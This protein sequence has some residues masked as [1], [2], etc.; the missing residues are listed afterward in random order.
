VTEQKRYKLI[1]KPQFGLAHAFYVFMGGFAFYGPYHDNKPPVEGG[2][3][4]FEISTNPC[5]TVE[6]PNSDAVIYIM[7]YFPHILTDI[8]EDYIHSQA[9]SSSLGKA[10]LTV[11]VAWFC[12]NCASRLFQ[13]LPLTLLEI[14]TAAHALCTLLTYIVWWS[15]P[16]NVPA[17]TI[18]RE[19][20]AQEVYALLNCSDDEYDKALEMAEKWV[21]GGSSTFPGTHESGKIVLAANALQY[22]LQRRL[23]T[24]E[25]PSHSVGFADSGYRLF[26]GTFDTVLSVSG[27]FVPISIAMA[28]SPILYGLVHFLAWNSKFP[29]L[30]EQVFWHVSSFVVTFSGLV[31]VP[32][33]FGM[34][35]LSDS[36]S[37]RGFLFFIPMAY[38]AGVVPIAHILA[39]GFL[40]VESFWQLASLDRDTY[41]AAYQLPSWS[42]YWPHIS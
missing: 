9:A 7:K 8:T 26:P 11:Q 10:L 22:A 12:T 27:R 36:K 6:Y 2:E 17:P 15:K 3:S 18:L 28:I 21:A 32:A 14:F 29:T 37:V 38:V 41:P 5:H 16:I 1:L 40:F 24:P 13:H 4:L 42:K 33:I 35:V 20:A 34:N 31:E 39:S 25:R 30:R 19:K 23:P